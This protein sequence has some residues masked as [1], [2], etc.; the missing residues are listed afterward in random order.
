MTRDDDPTQPLPA[1]GEPGPQ[2]EAAATEPLI[3]P[4]VPV[5]EVGTEEVAAMTPMTQTRSGSGARR[6]LVVGL[7]AALAAVI[8]VAVLS[9]LPRDGTPVPVDS[10]SPPVAP[11]PSVTEEVVDDGSD[12]A[13]DPAPPPPPDPVEPPP[14]P[15]PTPEPS[16]EP[17][18]TPTP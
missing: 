2:A 13:P 14:E 15:T 12:P 6:M 16:V 4:H 1:V 9:T 10:S 11:S 18:P 7:T 8:A 3:A 17:T 5:A